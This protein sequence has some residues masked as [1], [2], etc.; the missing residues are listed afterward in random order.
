MFC[1]LPV[2]GARAEGA[3]LE[4]PRGYERGGDKC[5]TLDEYKDLAVIVE[6]YHACMAQRAITLE[7]V[8]AL[9]AKSTLLQNASDSLSITV[10]DLE[11]G[12]RA[13][14]MA[15]TEAA[16]KERV[17]EQ[18]S[19][20]WRALATTGGVLSLALGAVVAGLAATR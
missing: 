2:S 4:A 11:H 13:A 6:R 3:E 12:R 14:L 15:A 9:E 18:R 5:F 17:Q 19:K 16:D 10:E 20:I 7:L 8:G 1:A